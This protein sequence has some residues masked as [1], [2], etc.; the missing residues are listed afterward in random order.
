MNLVKYKYNHLEELSEGEFYLWREVLLKV[1]LRMLRFKKSLVLISFFLINRKVKI[2]GS[3]VRILFVEP[4]LY[5]HVEP[6]QMPEAIERPLHV[7]RI[8][9]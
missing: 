1:W 9:N 5:R 2:L 4:K 3:L 8:A 6:G 7:D